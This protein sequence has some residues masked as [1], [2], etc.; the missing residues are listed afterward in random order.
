MASL[1]QEQLVTGRINRLYKLAQESDDYATVSFLKWFIDE[2]VEEEK[3]VFDMVE[4][5]K[6][7]GDKPDTLLLWTRWPL[8]ANLTTVIKS[9]SHQ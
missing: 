9:R 4:K 5:L 7:A 8:P 6:R 1:K 3:T 2:Q